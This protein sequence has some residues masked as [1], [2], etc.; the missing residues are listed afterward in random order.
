MKWCLVV[1]LTAVFI[2]PLRA[3][4]AWKSELTSP[5]LGNH[6]LPVSSVIDM[7]L[8]WKGMIESGILRIEFAPPDTTKTGTYIVRASASSVGAAAALFSY[9]GNFWAELE[10]TT[11]KPRLL[12]TV[13]VDQ[14]ESVNTTVRYFPDRIESHEESKL[15]KTGVTKPTDKTFNFAPV[16]DIFSAMLH[17]RSQKLDDGDLIVIVVCPF[18][19]PY[20]LKV[21]VQAHEIHDG[22]KAIR[23]S[24]GMQKINRDTLELRAYKKLKKDATLWLSDDGDRIPMELRAAAFIGDVRATLV[25]PKNPAPP[26][27]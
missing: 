24:L 7:R 8:S 12:N 19:T 17:V 25:N 4:P 5:A 11:L 15:L 6:P 18:S 21:K 14:K 23:L 27:K 20:I 26:Q 13:E 10:P 22:S 2:L 9:Q 16:F 1:P 3:E